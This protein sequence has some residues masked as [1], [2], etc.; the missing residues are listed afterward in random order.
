MRQVVTTL[1]DITAGVLIAVGLFG[2]NTS[3]GLVGTGT[4]VGIVS[5]KYAKP[6]AHPRPPLRERVNP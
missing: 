3:L 2:F 1:A 5:Y 4:M 6:V